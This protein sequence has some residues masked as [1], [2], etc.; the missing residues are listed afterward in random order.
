MD[1]LLLIHHTPPRRVTFVLSP[2]HLDKDS[3]AWQR[4]RQPDKQMLF[5]IDPLAAQHTMRMGVLSSTIPSAV[6]DTSATLSAFLTSG[7]SLPMGRVS[8]AV[9]HLPN[10]AAKATAVNKLLH[11][12]QAP[13]R[14]VNIVLSLVGNS[15]LSTSK[16]A[17]AGYTAIYDKDEVNLYNARTTKIMVSSDMVLRGWQCPHMNLWC[18]PLVPFIT[19]L[20]TGTLILDHPSGQE[21]LNSMYTIETNQ[22]THKHVALQM[23]KNHCQEYLNNVYELPSD[24]PTT[25]YLHGAAGFPTKASWLKAIR[26]ENYLSWPLINVKNVAKCFP[27]SEETQK[28]HMRGQCQRVQSTKVAEPTEDA[29]TTLPHQK[30]NDILIT[31]HE[32]KSLMYADQTGLFPA[33]SSL[34]NKYVMIL[35]HVDRNSSWLE[36]MQNQLGGKLILARARAL[37]WMQRCRLIPKHQILNNQ[38]AK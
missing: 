1:V 13:A 14:N 25:W 28:G 34:G 15:F 11:D 8:S 12:V 5:C 9:F 21:S 19:N 31:E 3:T 20:N 26:K 23:C 33:V 17:E 18:V 2:Y 7:P 30:K 32:V 6:S 37:A 38:S 16:F 29:P 27:E 22:H 36:A 4:G 24:E 35:H 10:G